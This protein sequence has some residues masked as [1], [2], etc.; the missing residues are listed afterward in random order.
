VDADALRALAHPVDGV[1][2]RVV[3]TQETAATV[4]ITSSQADQFRL[5]ELLDA[6]KPP[7]PADA[8]GLSYL[9]STPFRYPPLDYG[10]RFGSVF[11]RGIFYASTHL[12][13]SFAE[14]AV[15]LWLFRAALVDIGPLS[16]IRDERSSYSVKLRTVSGIKLCATAFDGIRA[17]LIR[18]D[19]WSDSQ[20]FGSSLRAAAIGALWY[21][22]ARIDGENVA[23]FEPGVF[24]SKKESNLRSWHVL[25]TD[26]RCWFGS[27]D[28]ADNYE[29]FFDQFAHNG[30]I[31]HATASTGNGE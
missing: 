25:L 15:Y 22:S 8:A 19:R 31:A 5:E 9:L 30:A 29:Y 11:E 13:T 21:P 28:R 20:A 10:S 2:W 23:I 16:E 6:S 3:E 14:S 4:S 7:V 18:P 26:D 17:E 27:A 24:R 12:Q 1:C